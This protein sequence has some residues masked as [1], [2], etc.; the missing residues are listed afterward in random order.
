MKTWSG[1]E[2]PIDAE[3]LSPINPLDLVIVLG[4][5]RRYGGT[6]SVEWSVLHHS[7]LTAM[8]WL[9]GGYAVEDLHVPLL[10]D[11]HEAYLG[12]IPQPVKKAL[13]AGYPHLLA[14][15]KIVQDR[16]ADSFD[17]PFVKEEQRRQL[18]LCDFAALLIDSTFAAAPGC[19]DKVLELDL[20]RFSAEDQKEL[21]RLVEATVPNFKTLPRLR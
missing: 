17:L 1:A 18:K 15:E 11:A 12:D 20:V 16:I 9:R 10:H 8:V 19:H 6:G 4:R 7:V 13:G 5:T 3:P 14:L 2:A 21:W